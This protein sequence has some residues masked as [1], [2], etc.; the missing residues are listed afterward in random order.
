MKHA[1]I[2]RFA[3]LESPIHG[4][5]PSLKIR[6]TFLAL[7]LLLFG[8]PILTIPHIWHG[9]LLYAGLILLAALISRVPFPFLLTRSALVLPFSVL[10]VVVNYFSGNFSFPQMIE[11]VCKSLLSIFTLLLLSSTTPF[12]E[13]LKQLSR[14]RAPKLFIIILSFMYRYF[15]L[16]AGE[17]EALERAVHMRH[18]SVSGWK[19]I[20]VY[21]NMISMLLVRSYER[22]ENV[23]Q[24][25]QMRGFTGDFR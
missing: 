25:M 24:A 14:W 3:S 9:L 8:I 21:T 17:I 2:D 18:S 13:I 6:L 19:R 12:H 7:V 4:L 23:Y 1:F 11:T 22:A 5:T 20:L 15:F 16:L 10:I